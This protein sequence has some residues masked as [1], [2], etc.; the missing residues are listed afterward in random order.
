MKL[1]RKLFTIFGGLALLA[2]S[3]AGATLWATAQ[4]QSTEEQLQNHFQ[5]SLLLQ[6]VRA[7]T[8]RAFK[9]VPDAIMTNDPD[10]PQEFELALRSVEQ[11]FQQWQKLAET[12]EEKQQVQQVRAAYDELVKDARQ[13]FQLVQAGQRRQATTLMEGRLEEQN[14]QRFEALSAQAVESDRRYREVVRTNTQNT[15]QTTQLILTI[16][17]FGILSLMLLLAAY[18]AS[19]LFAPLREAEQALDEVA[20]GNLQ[21]RLS[22]DRQDELGDIHRAFNRMMAE[23]A[24]REQT[25]ELTMVSA[26]GAQPATSDVALQDMPSRL[27]LHTLVSQVRSRVNQ[28]HQASTTNGNASATT[29]PQQEMMQQLDHLLQAISR[30]TEFGFPVDLN[31]A[32]TDIRALLYDV[33]LRFQEDF[34]R[35]HVSY[36]LQ[37]APDV[38][39]ATIDRLKLR[40]VLG[41]LVRNAIAALPDQG[42]RIGIR[43]SLLTDHTELLLEVADDGEGTEQPL[44]NQALSSL[45]DH[46]D[47][48]LNVGLKLARAVVEQHG[49]QLTIDSE[50][51]QGTHVQMRLPLRN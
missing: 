29:E 42:G 41:E 34:V 3:T 13:T 15:R 36:E 37:I 2:L 39:Y 1:Q 35:R 43:A 10:A 22:T 8:F 46:P 7:A 26:H 47:Q 23:I 19:D 33:L 9:E 11:D 28:L 27:T 25:L 18:L 31:L 32:R 21:R 51:N 5:R 20:Q 38:H 12:D 49:G 24:Q 14:F 17:A 48:R 50:P 16:A 4:W 45:D 44:I 6:R 30:I 40:E